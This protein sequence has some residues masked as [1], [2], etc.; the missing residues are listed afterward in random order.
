MEYMCALCDQPVFGRAV[1][2]EHFRVL[3]E[4]G[5]FNKA[6]NGEPQRWL[7]DFIK[8][9]EPTDE[10]QFFPFPHSGRPRVHV[11][12]GKYE[13]VTRIILSAVERMPKRGEEAC[14]APVICN[15]GTCINPGHLR[16]GTTSENHQDKILDGTH[17]R[18]AKNKKTKLTEAQVLEIVRRSLDGE[19]AEE[20]GQGIGISRY[21]IHDIM[22]G[23]S[24][25]WL[26]GIKRGEA[27]R[28]RGGSAHGMSKLTEYQVLEIVRRCQ[29]G[30]SRSSVARDF[31]VRPAT[32]GDIMR[33]STW[34]K[35]TGL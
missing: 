17:S 34:G 22:R 1:C 31:K 12:G 26:T 35:V 16:W 29:S 15:D 21:A 30:E 11:G 18:G 5:S 13:M 19:T 24:W 14:H 23:R 4:A 2:L 7:K 32:V 33:G 28:T 8:N 27:P 10:C 20:V 3:S 9:H 25:S 6:K